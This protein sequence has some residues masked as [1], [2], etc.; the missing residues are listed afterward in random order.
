VQEGFFGMSR[1]RRAAFRLALLPAL[2]GLLATLLVGVSAAPASAAVKPGTN[3]FA[4]RVLSEAAKHDG[5]QYRY[6][7]N[8]PRVFDCSGFTRYVYSKA[9]GKKLPRTSRDQYRAVRKIPR[10]QVKRGDLVFFRNSSGRV[11]HVAIYAGNGKIWHASNPRTDVQRGK[12]WSK[13][14]VAG[15]VR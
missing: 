14:W 7:G 9:V 8:G 11:Y 6:G 10:S 12:I 5:K 3:A 4:S 15:R 2:L 1:A 13:N